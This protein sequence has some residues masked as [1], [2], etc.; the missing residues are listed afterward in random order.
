[1]KQTIKDPLVPSHQS[2]QQRALPLLAHLVTAAAAIVAVG[3]VVAVVRRRSDRRRRRQRAWEDN[4]AQCKERIL[5]RPSKDTMAA[6]VVTEHPQQTWDEL[7]SVVRRYLSQTF[8]RPSEDRNRQ[9]KEQ[10]DAEEDAEEEPRPVGMVPHSAK[11]AQVGYVRLGGNWWA[12]YRARQTTTAQGLLWI[13]QVSAL[14]V[15]SKNRDNVETSRKASNSDHHSGGLSSIWRG[16]R[17]FVALLGQY[18]DPLLTIWICDAFAR[19]ELSYA[20]VSWR[21]GA[22]TLLDSSPPFHDNSHTTSSDNFDATLWRGEAIR[23]LAELTLLPHLL[24]PH[25]GIVVWREAKT[26]GEA[27]PP[28]TTGTPTT[29]Q[30]I[31]ELSQSPTDAFA[32]PTP[33]QLVATFDASTGLLH[34]LHGARPRLMGRDKDFVTHTWVARFGDCRWNEA[35][36][37]WYPSKVEAGWIDGDCE[38]GDDN[39]KVDDWRGKLVMAVHAEQEHVQYDL[40]TPRFAE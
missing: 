27:T 18:F 1:M 36:L 14:G 6:A 4:V 19:N 21:R 24:L 20:S 39:D 22:V 28:N 37:C 34:Q 8:H 32:P 33:I 23:W 2:F 5:I 26:S 16:L 12:P 10:E 38:A 35:A 30:A 40:G 3:T 7:P 31:L 13:A 29:T 17:G 15:V 11:F 9:Q 25:A